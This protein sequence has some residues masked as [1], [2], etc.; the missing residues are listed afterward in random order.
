M[1]RLVTVYTIGLATMPCQQVWSSSSTDLR[2]YRW[3]DSSTLFKER[4]LPLICTDM[5]RHLTDLRQGGRRLAARPDRTRKLCGRR[6]KVAVESA[7]EHVAMKGTVKQ[8]VRI[9]GGS[10]SQII[11]NRWI[12]G[13]EE[14]PPVCRISSR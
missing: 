4:C 12:G 9:G 13:S 6:T 3:S 1:G 5:T 11:P 8:A 7:G 2:C 10:D 14:S